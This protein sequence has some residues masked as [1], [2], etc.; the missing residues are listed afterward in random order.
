MHGAMKLSPRLRGHAERSEASHP[1]NGEMLRC[2][3]HDK[4]LQLMS[5]LA[6]SCTIL[7]STGGGDKGE[8][9]RRDRHSRGVPILSIAAPWNGTVSVTL[10][11]A[12]GRSF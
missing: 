11:S 2:A 6:R 8:G 12:A 5:H 3:Q 4:Q 10:P 9:E 7:R 1:S